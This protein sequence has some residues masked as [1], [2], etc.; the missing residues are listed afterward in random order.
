M[1]EN[2]INKSVEVVTVPP[3]GGQQRI[4][5][6][7]INSDVPR[8]IDVKIKDLNINDYN[9]QFVGAANIFSTTS[10][11]RDVCHIPVPNEYLDKTNSFDMDVSYEPYNLIYRTLQNE[12]QFPINNFNIQINYKDFNTNREVSI[13]EI[14]GTLKLELHIKQERL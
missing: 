11:T 5:Y 4:N 1:G 7:G 13:D 8:M 3:I 12:H 9:G 2:E 14:N 10:I 6:L